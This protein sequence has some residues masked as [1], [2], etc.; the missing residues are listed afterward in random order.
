MMVTLVL[1][2]ALLARPA[3]AAPFD[4]TS[5]DW[6]G[7][8]EFV[9][10]ARAELGAERVVVATHLDLHELSPDD[11]LVILFPAQ[12]LPADDLS[13]FMRAGGRVVLLDDFG[14]G[15][16]LLK[17]FGIERIASPASPV[18]KL[19]HNPQFAIAEPASTHP[20]VTDITRVVTNHPTGL[21]HP[22][23]SPVLAI[24]AD[25]AGQGNG[26]VAIAVAGLVGQGRLLAV[27]DP[28]I[29]MNSMLRYAGNKS[30]ARGVI[31]YAV[32]QDTWGKRGGKLFVLSGAFDQK[33]AFGAEE[34]TFKAIVT[35]LGEALETARRDGASNA[36]A[37]A[38]AI[39]LGLVLAAWVVLRA[40]RLHKPVVPRFVRPTPAALQGGVAGHAAVIAAPQT[41]RVLAVLELRSALE[42]HLTTRLGLTQIPRS[43]EL[44]AHVRRAQLLDVEGLHMLQKLLLRMSKLETTMENSGR[45]LQRVHDSEVVSI[46]KT[47]E[48]LA[49]RIERATDRAEESA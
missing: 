8:A 43:E 17:H 14:R 44:I 18:E 11:G 24:R 25:R 46:A 4:L 15:D 10:L 1:L 37:Y 42:E 45:L 36:V 3:R 29:V 22:S 47:I 21:A 12:A 28:S 6:E 27:G 30:F 9:H 26:D 7:C 19:R 16:A 13:K 49:R 41:K 32:D 2:W 20:V 40:G 33:G 5:D 34:G 38:S 48:Q 31:H 23:L 39:A 35:T